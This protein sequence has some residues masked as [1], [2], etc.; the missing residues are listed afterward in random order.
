MLIQVEDLNS[1][2][3][4]IVKASLSGSQTVSVL[5]FVPLTVDSLAAACIL[6]ELF[7]KDNL[8]NHFVPVRGYADLTQ[9]ITA[10]MTDE[11]VPPSVIFLNCG[12]S[13]SL[14]RKFP[15]AFRQSTAY[16]IDS[17]R[18]VHLENIDSRVDRIKV[19]DD[20]QSV[21]D[22]LFELP[23]SEVD[24]EHSIIVEVRQKTRT[25]NRLVAKR[26][27]PDSRAVAR[28]LE[29]SRF[30][31]PAALQLYSLAT[32]RN[33]TSLQILWFAILGLTEHFLLEHVDSDRYEVLFN[34]LQNEASRL[35]NGLELFTTIHADDGD[36]VSPV[37]T[38]TVPVAANLF[39]QP[40]LDLRFTLMRHWT[41]MDAM[42]YS[43]FVASRLRLWTHEGNERLHILLAKMGVPLR[44]A[45]TAYIAMSSDLRESLVRRFDTHC[46]AQNLTGGH[47]ASFLL[48]RGYAAHLAASDVVYAV[49]ARLSTGQ[50]FGAAFAETFTV[51]RMAGNQAL[52]NDGVESAKLRTKQV[53]SIGIELMNRRASSIVNA[54]TF[55]IAYIHNAAERG[56]P[57]ETSALIDLAQ[58]LIQAY[59][60][61]G[62]T[63]LP[64]IVASVDQVSQ[65]WLV[66]AVSTAFEFGDVEA[67]KFGTWF[68]QAAA[69]AEIEI[70]LDSFDSF[71]CQV[72]NDLLLAFVDQ[73]TLVASR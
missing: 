46:D 26:I 41:L 68:G 39:I 63:V 3:Q 15:D 59:R 17:H 9:H 22:E 61:N 1:V 23:D 58:F 53:I 65:Q 18:P 44:D 38:I 64:M 10:R 13:I 34:A 57:V 20:S 33:Q 6:Y 42:Q 16:V 71:V 29:S 25:V 50:D 73:L 5:I 21:F 36:I 60:A 28:F 66:V 51:V 7:R 37:T 40:C 55:R 31:D 4:E 45:N 69:R 11:T 32:A 56:F 35:T 43:P 24:D 52:L 8:L 2:Y 12:G 30:S 72:P 47:F 70:G 54:G 27:D 67:S 48:K 14:L 49:R 19:F 62:D